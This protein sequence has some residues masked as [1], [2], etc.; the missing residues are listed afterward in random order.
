MHPPKKSTTPHAT[1]R[2]PHGLTS[3]HHQPLSKHFATS[4]AEVV[5]IWDY[6][7]REPTHNYSWGHDTVRKVRFNSVETHLLAACMSDRGIVLIDTRIQT[8]LQKTIL[9]MGSNAVAWNPVEPYML[10]SASE[11]GN[12]YTFDTRKFDTPLQTH[13]DHIKAVI[14]LDYSPTG[15]E[16]VT[17]AYDST[18]RIFPVDLLEANNSREVYHTKRMQRVCAV[19]YS[20]DATFVFSG[21]DDTN[22]RI[23]KSQASQPLRP[24]SHRAQEKLHYAGKLK[25]KYAS[26]PLVRSIHNHKQVPGFIYKGKTMKHIKHMSVEMR[27]QRSLA[28]IQNPDVKKEKLRKAKQKQNPVVA[29]QE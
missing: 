21:S 27:T 13:R 6:E 10:S 12:C 25:E 29:E 22:I 26:F 4:G 28:R 11:D 3:V 5:S 16:F 19:K 18:I 15:R 23:W 17:G 9:T 20:A 2:A 24:L 7:R 14:D 1:F 8:N